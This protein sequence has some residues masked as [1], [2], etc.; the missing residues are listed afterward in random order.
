MKLY[1]IAHL[2]IGYIFYSTLEKHKKSII[3]SNI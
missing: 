2:F 1:F 3:E